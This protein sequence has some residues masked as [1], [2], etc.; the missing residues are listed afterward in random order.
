[1]SFLLEWSTWRR[2][3]QAAARCRKTG[4]LAAKRSAK[5]TAGRG[6]PPEAVTIAPEERRLTDEQWASVRPLLPAPK[7]GGRRTAPRPP[8][9]PGRDLVGGEDRVVLARD[10]GGIRQM[11]GSLPAPRASGRAGPVAAHPPGF[12][13]G[14][15]AGTG[16]EGAQVMLWGKLR[17]GFEQTRGAGSWREGGISVGG[18]IVPQGTEDGVGLCYKFWSGT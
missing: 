9:G 10:A 3:H 1:M 6:R 18:H 11:G 17:I 7:G 4:Y 14:S 5:A 16:D 8:R 13:R 12:R 2:A 15:R